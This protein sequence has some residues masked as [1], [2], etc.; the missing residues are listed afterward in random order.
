MKGNA[1]QSDFLRVCACV[2]ICVSVPVC[3]Y[4]RSYMC[5]FVSVCVCVCVCMAAR[6]KGKKRRNNSV[7]FSTLK[8][9]PGEW[10]VF[11]GFPSKEVK[12]R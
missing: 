8:T 6:K 5:V 1:A 3:E 7:S 9:E 4:V 10:R 2:Y 12:K 11:W